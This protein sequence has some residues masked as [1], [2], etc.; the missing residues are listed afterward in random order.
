MLKPWDYEVY[1]LKH[2]E[3]IILP[4]RTV[5]H[6]CLPGKVHSIDIIF[7][8]IITISIGKDIVGF[9]VFGIK[10]A[11]AL[12]SYNEIL[13]LSGPHLINRD[14]NLASQSCCGDEHRDVKTF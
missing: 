9:R 6:S 14:N 5:K 2:L 11:L 13:H 8:F 12:T 3:L 7:V 1:L 4:I 10:P